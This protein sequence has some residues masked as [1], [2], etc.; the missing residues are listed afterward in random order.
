MNFNEYMREKQNITLATTYDV[1]LIIHQLVINKCVKFIDQVLTFFSSTSCTNSK[2]ATPALGAP[3]IGCIVDILA[4][5]EMRKRSSPSTVRCGRE[6]SERSVRKLTKNFMLSLELQNRQIH[7]IQTAISLYIPL[8]RLD[9]GSSSLF[10]KLYHLEYIY[11]FLSARTKIL[12]EF[13][14]PRTPV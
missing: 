1:T 13:L 12:D 14:R 2:L 11:I 7:L 4:G 3:K 9:I 8:P 10:I 6:E 5:E